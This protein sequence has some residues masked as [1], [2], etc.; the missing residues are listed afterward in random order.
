MT[1]FIDYMMEHTFLTAEEIDRVVRASIVRRIPHRQHLL[2]E[3]AVWKWHVFV[4]KGCLRTYFI[5]PG[6]KHQT[7]AFAVPG[8]WTG[9]RESMAS[10]KPSQ[11]NIHALQD[12]EVTLIA[13]T[14]FQALRKSIAG[15]N[16]LAN[17]IILHAYRRSQK[18]IFSSLSHTV[19]QKLAI[20]RADYPT[21]ADSIPKHMLASYFG[22]SFEYFSR[23]QTGKYNRKG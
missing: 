12:S 21:I 14:E 11:F 10:G 4:T 3:G 9:D 15:F 8:T 7:I 22:I 16:A 19:D 23:S 2:R 18:R 20:F 5:D 1:E 6:D 13:D 17:N